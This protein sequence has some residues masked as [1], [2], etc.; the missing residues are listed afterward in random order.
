MRK[1][2]ST[3]NHAAQSKDIHSECCNITQTVSDKFQWKHVNQV[4]DFIL[5]TLTIYYQLHTLL[6]LKQLCPNNVL[7]QTASIIITLTT[8]ALLTNFDIIS[9]L[10]STNPLTSK[11]LL[12]LYYLFHHNCVSY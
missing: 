12:D 8:L 4:D 10:I 3:N 6:Y 7:S 5:K 11:L 2:Q 1:N 9:A